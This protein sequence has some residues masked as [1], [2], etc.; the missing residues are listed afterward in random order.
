M[1]ARLIGSTIF[2]VRPFTEFLRNRRNCFRY[3]R[4][5]TLEHGISI[6]DYL[7]YYIPELKQRSRFRSNK[8]RNID[9]LHQ[10][11]VIVENIKNS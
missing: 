10:K 9:L 11:C 8:N 2:Q 1:N 7:D 5:R 3:Y 4:G 6:T